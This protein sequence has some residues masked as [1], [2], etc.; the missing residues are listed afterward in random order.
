MLFRGSY[1]SIRKQPDHFLRDLLVI[2]VPHMNV[3]SSQCVW[4]LIL[5]MLLA[6]RWAWC[7]QSPDDLSLPSGFR[8]E[9]YADD[10]LA[11][12]IHCLTLDSQGRV[13]VS[14]VGYVR[15]LLDTDHDNVADRVQEFTAGPETGAQGMYF[16]GPDLIC[17]GDGG[18]LKYRDAN[19][20][21]QA[22]GPAEVLMPLKTGGEH[23]AHSVQKGPD[24]WWYVLVGNFAGVSARDV[25]DPRS[26]IRQPQAGVVLR[27]SPDFQS[28]QVLTDGFRNPYDFAFSAQGDLF[29]FDSDEEREVSLPW[30]RP[31][32]VFQLLPGRSAGWMSPSWIR[33]DDDPDMLPVV[34]SCGRGS[35][36]GVVCYQHTQFP[37]EFRQTLFL[38]DWTFGRILNVPLQP[39]GSVTQG[40]VKTFLAVSGKFGL[41]PTDVAVGPAG[42]LFVSVG[43][44]GTRGGVYR[45]YY[46]AEAD[47]AHDTLNAPADDPLTQC[48][49]AP[50]PLDS[51]SRAQWI[52]LAIQLGPQAFLASAR[53]VELSEDQRVRAIE[54][55]TELFAGLDGETVRALA[56]DTSATVRARAAWS[57]GVSAPS[58]GL[59]DWLS[60]FMYDSDPRVQRLALETAY[61]HAEHGLPSTLTPRLSQLLEA[62]DRQVRLAAG[63]VVSRLPAPAFDAIA[64]QVPRLT[65]TGQ[66]AFMRSQVS[67]SREPNSTV[68]ADAITWLNRTA[69]VE[70]KRDVLRLAQQ[71]LGDFGLGGPFPPVWNGYANSCNLEDLTAS[72]SS[73][74]ADLF[75]MDQPDLNRELSQIFAL[76]SID[77]PRAMDTLVGQLTADSHP[78][79]DIHYLI[80]LSRLP[81]PRTDH[82]RQVI[83]QTLVSLE[84]K[85]VARN[86]H[87]DS[88]WDLRVGEMYAQLVRRDPLLLAAVIADPGFGQ[89]G[90]VLFTK[91]AS[92]E[93]LARAADRV[94]EYLQ[95]Y[96]DWTWTPD[97]IAL[98]AQS[99]EPRHR[100]LIR[101][102]F[103]DISLHG[104]IVRA[105]SPRPD[106]RDRRHFVQGLMSP[107]LAVVSA[108]VSALERLPAS[109]DP[110]SQFALLSTLRRLGT[111]RQEQSLATRVERLMRHNLGQDF[112]APDSSDAAEVRKLTIQNWTEQLRQRF[113]TA[114]QQYLRTEKEEQARVQEALGRVPWGDGQLERGKLLFQKHSCSGCHNARAAVG[115]DLTG[116]AKRFS[117]DDLF[118]ALLFPN[119][120]V[121]PRYHTTL[122]ETASGKI[123]SGLVIY[124]SAEGLTLR[125]STNQTIRVEA[126]EIDARRDLP[127]SLMPDGLLE[128]LQPQELADLYAYLQTL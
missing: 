84:P 85:L 39:N 112:N 10:E 86:L 6:P 11:H 28:R 64:Q 27:I 90:H 128:T 18:L 93:L 12:D 80:V 88:N 98:L 44:R 7:V 94:V 17:T 113:P 103:A 4:T 3:S 107:D 23:H 125:D 123:L 116:V 48:L 29:T 70:Q 65:R 115:P 45:I 92:P 51:W 49:A 66:I 77:S 119:R 60:L 117:R 59:W 71:A 121:S 37:A 111:E 89:P 124:E 76:L 47:T 75:P 50:Q 2:A 99:P 105:L 42:D 19:R 122:V 30:Y 62:P 21:G 9:L 63:D 74:L 46:A 108:A 97:V 102:Q 114:A 55:L 41:A 83:A 40:S 127:T 67:R 120:D 56:T 36:T 110:D 106:V 69:M 79:D 87:Q 109:E 81:T 57:L 100:E 95:T 126:A 8:C 33:A 82:H 26:P 13:V 14:S 25:T 118:T 16:D 104:A 91:G 61:L 68:F 38:L 72:S 43:G 15:V 22:D 101:A 32:R 35:P 5:A 24:G 52:P 73:M 34:A 31:T 58:D 78:V 53:D 1:V 54:I 96:P 20:D